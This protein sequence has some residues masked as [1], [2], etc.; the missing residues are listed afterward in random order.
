[1]KLEIIVFGIT[2]F[3][4]YNTYHDGK[5]IEILKS[6]QKYYKMATIGFV[7]LTLYLF[8]KR[9]PTQSKEMVTYAN[10]VIKYMPIDKTT[11]NMIA[12]IFDF[13][14]GKL[15]N[16]SLKNNLDPNMTPQ[17]N[18]MMSS[19]GGRATNGGTI[20]RS[21]SESKKKYVASRQ[22]WKCDHCKEMLDA[23]Y[24][25]DHVIELQHGGTNHIDNLVALCRNCHGKK[26]IKSYL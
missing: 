12:P 4:I 1:M 16:N 25:I 15:S 13:T 2:G 18:R 14:M 22:S 24:E 10:D 8:F 17:M 26:T 19:G 23:T 6:W 11:S 3:L 9:N 20:K 5:Y 21:V 7:G